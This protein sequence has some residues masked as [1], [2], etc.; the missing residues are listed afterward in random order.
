MP[1]LIICV[2]EYPDDILIYNSRNN[3]IIKDTRS[4]SQSKL[5]GKLTQTNSS[6][7]LAVSETSKRKLFYINKCSW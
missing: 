6:N 1:L 4:F 3:S 2:N 7:L 5:S